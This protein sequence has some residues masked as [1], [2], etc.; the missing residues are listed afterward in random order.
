MKPAPK[1]KSKSAPETRRIVTVADQ[2]LAARCAQG[3]VVLIDDDAP[4]LDALGSLLAQE[5]YAVMAH[6]SAT[7][8]L[9]AAAR[10]APQFEGPCCLVC[11]VMMPDVD[12]LALQQRLAQTPAHDTVP[13]V[14]MSGASGAREAAS[15]FKAG[16]LDFLIKPIDADTLLN[17]VALALDISRQRQISGKHQNNLAQRIA[18]LS[19]REREIARRVAQG[20]SNPR[21]AADL[22]IA[23]RTVKLHRQRAIEKLGAAGLPDLVRMAAAGNL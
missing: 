15:A 23:L 13:I 1:S 6:S 12:G 20:Q 4:V 11:D 19:A 7:G 14:L 8:Y 16:A 2:I 10:N 17:A 5:G 22:G 3:K 18:T 9:E 21:I